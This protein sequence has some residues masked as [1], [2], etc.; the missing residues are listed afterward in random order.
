MSSQRS[1]PL[2]RASKGDPLRLNTRRLRLLSRRYRQTW[3]RDQPAECS[4]GVQSSPG[5]HRH[6]RNPEPTPKPH[7]GPRR[8]RHKPQIPVS[9]YLRPKSA[10]LRLRPSEMDYRGH[11][12]ILQDPGLRATRWRHHCRLKQRRLHLSQEG[13]RRQHL[14]NSG[15]L[16]ISRNIKDIR[17]QPDSRQA[18]LIPPSHPLILDERQPSRKPNHTTR[19]HRHGSRLHLLSRPSRHRS[20]RLRPI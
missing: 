4:Q 18:P 20:R 9:L 19:H 2:S 1:R 11:S 8:R 17:R 5:P 7:R 3:P 16:F 13:Q 15:L 14:R 10:V 12:S 6:R